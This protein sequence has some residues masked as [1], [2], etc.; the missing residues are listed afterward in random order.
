MPTA[1]IFSAAFEYDDQDPDGYR[2]G[3]ARVGAAGRR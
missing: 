3:V 1:N 2:S